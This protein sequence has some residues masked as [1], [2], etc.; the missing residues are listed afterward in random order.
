[1]KTILIYLVGYESCPVNGG[2]S[3]FEWYPSKSIADK[4]YFDTLKVFMNSSQSVYRGE[5]EVEVGEDYKGTL[6]EREEITERVEKFLEENEWEK[7][8]EKKKG[9]FKT[10]RH[11]LP[12]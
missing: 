1:M 5:F 12:L 2:T 8:F 7:A 3:G 9:C 11:K 10:I 4:D 6:D